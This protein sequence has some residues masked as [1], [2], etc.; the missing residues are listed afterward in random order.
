MIELSVQ[1]I[2]S[3]MM[4]K[5]I[6]CGVRNQQVLQMK[7][8]IQDI[9][10]FWKWVRESRNKIK[11]E[12][13]DIECQLHKLKVC[14]EY[15]DISTSKFDEE[16]NACLK[17]IKKLKEK[18]AE[19][20]SVPLKL[21]KENAREDHGYSDKNNSRG[22][23]DS[24][25]ETNSEVR[26]EVVEQNMAKLNE[27]NY[28]QGKNI[29]GTGEFESRNNL[30]QP[31]ELKSLTLGE[32]KSELSDLERDLEKVVKKFSVEFEE[33]TNEY[34]D[35]ISKSVSSKEKELEKRNILEEQ[36]KKSPTQIF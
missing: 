27:A 35:L 24:E 23:C 12:I 7:N 34:T 8:K 26:L 17:K 28:V 31:K 29:V 20:G 4:H 19:Y 15:C 13:T 33:L 22:M 1:E 10:G 3:K 11:D 30:K 25:C 18:L 14:V 5:E 36:N 9:E 2:E 21:E 32:I 6:D 16:A